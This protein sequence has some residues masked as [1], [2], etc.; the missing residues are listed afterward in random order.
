MSLLPSNKQKYMA[1]IITIDSTTEAE[2]LARM[3]RSME[4]KDIELMKEMI[5]VK[6]PNWEKEMSD[7]NEI[8]GECEEVDW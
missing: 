7:R 1:N 2:G 5:L 8:G 6:E 3:K 4:V